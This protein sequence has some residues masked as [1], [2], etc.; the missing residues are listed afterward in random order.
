[1]SRMRA[2]PEDVAAARRGRIIQRVLV[3]GWTPAEA[4]A[5]FG[6]S[7]R[8]VAKWVAAYRRFGMASLGDTPAID[9]DLRCRLRRLRS[10]FLRHLPGPRDEHP[11]ATARLVKLRP[12]A[13]ENPRDDTRR[14]SLWR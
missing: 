6:I 5:A 9:G 14:R 2:N 8:Q 3:D 7:E 10:W 4:G 13:D 11:G 12:A 1:M